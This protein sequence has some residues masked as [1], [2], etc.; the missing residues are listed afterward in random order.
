VCRPQAPAG[1]WRNGST[2]WTVAF[3]ST[4]PPAPST[5]PTA[6][7]A[8]SR[9]RRNDGPGRESRNAIAAALAADHGGVVH[10]EALRLNRITKD[11]VRTE[12]SAGRWRLL[13]RH[14]VLIGN[15]TPSEVGLR[16]RAVWESGGGS[17]LDGV[18]ALLASGL[19]GYTPE[20]I[21]VSIPHANR[22]HDVEGVRLHR[23]RRSFLPRAGGVPR[24]PVDVAAIHGAT[25]AKSERQAALIL[26]LVVQQRLAPADH[27]RKRALELTTG[28]RGAFIRQVT[29]DLADGAHSLGELDFSVLCR[30]AGLPEPSRQVVRQGPDGRIYLDVAWRGTHLVVEIDG[31]HHQLGLNPVDDA[32]RQNSVTLG[33]AHVLRIPVLGL[34]LQP[35]AFMAQVVQGFEQWAVTD[36]AA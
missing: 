20:S 18:A 12:V 26:C 9:K 32:L 14:T 30:G 27:L 25:W 15:G 8:I 28:K 35:E 21:D 11:G 33:Q 19:T 1:P 24:L 4:E 34:R 6:P 31:A 13:G 3:M 2:Q 36:S 23:R 22:D 7:S 29:L 10:R 16:W 17:M 5:Q